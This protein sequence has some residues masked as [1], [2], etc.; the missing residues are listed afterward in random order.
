M[1]IL[2]FTEWFWPQI[3]GLQVLSAQLLSALRDR[4]HSVVVITEDDFG[5]L[6]ASDT[7]RGIPV[8]RFGLVPALHARDV[9]R[10]AAARR[11]IGDLCRTF[12]PDVIHC[13]FSPLGAYHV[14]E[15]FAAQEAPILLSF[16]GSVAEPGQPGR[17][18]LLGRAL[19]SAAWVTGCSK[20]TLK[21]VRMLDPRIAAR[22]SVIYNA[23]EMPFGPIAPLPGSP[24]VIAASGRMYH[25]KGFDVLLDAF[26][27]VS[28]SLSDVRLVLMGDGPERSALEKQ[29][30]A[31]G[32]GHS[33]SFTGWVAPSKITEEIDR[34][35]LMVVPSREEG[36]GLSALEAA[37]RGR[38]TIAARVGGLPEVLGD[39][40]PGLFFESE[41]SD[42][43]AAA[44]LALLADPARIRRVGN[45]A[46]QRAARLFS[47][48]RHVAEH[49]ALYHRLVTEPD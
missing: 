16:H 4:D 14:A 13:A 1:R 12:A 8:H 22:S 44:L 39:E 41:R 2:Y 32:V 24:K 11:S 48:P 28:G 19:A 40:E 6:P 42:Q 34:A 7:F 37:I 30:D 31:L 26:A 46:R 17:P 43:L 47:A 35:T 38:A 27:I 25:Q 29:A 18:N 20:A 5:S 9:E 10:I 49:E 15:I 21:D 36:F 33:V 45:A 3:G 23:S